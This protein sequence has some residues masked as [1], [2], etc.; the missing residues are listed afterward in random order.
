MILYNLFVVY[1]IGRQSIEVD[2]VARAPEIIVGP[3]GLIEGAAHEV[4]EN[5]HD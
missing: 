4:C 3:T 5:L 1:N 2:V